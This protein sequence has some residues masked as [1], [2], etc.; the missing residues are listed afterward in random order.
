MSA[1]DIDAEVMAHFRA[2]TDTSHL[3]FV[4]GAGASAPS[5]LPDWNTLTTRLAV[6]TGVVPS[7]HAARTLIEAQDPSFLLE[8]A[9]TRAAEEWSQLVGEALYSGLDGPLRPS[10]LHLAIAAHYTQFPHRTSLATLNFDTLL[11][12]ALLAAGVDEIRVATSAYDFQSANASV[13][14]LHGALES[15]DYGAHRNH[16]MVVTYRDYAELLAENSP[17]QLEYLTQALDRGPLLLTGS[18]YRDPDLRHWLHKALPSSSNPALVTIVRE[19]LR[20]DSQTFKEVRPALQE[21]WESIGLSA[22]TLHDFSDIALI[23]RELPTAGHS[24]YVA[25]KGRAIATF[26]RHNERF[27]ELQV[28]FSEALSAAARRLK[29]VFG[30]MP[31]RSTFWLANGQSELV[32]WATAE[33]HYRSPDQFKRVPIGHDSPW[34]AGQTLATEEVQLRAVDARQ[35]SSPKWHSVLAIP[36]FVSDGVHPR[37]CAAVLT[38]AVART[39]NSVASLRAQW[40]GIAQELSAEWSKRISGVGFAASASTMSVKRGGD[41]GG[42]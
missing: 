9:R 34:I 42:D 21:Q 5:G 25:P 14:H 33:G 15:T 3:T 32:R 1:P 2:I 13:A 18:T 16:E 27:A 8:A 31:V 7:E 29:H 41:H 40:A 11:E 17:W 36:V 22:L 38:F 35:H 19:G 28:E 26:R 10:P 4:I 24:G 37:V 12:E 6:R 39:A 23:V 30:K 20:L